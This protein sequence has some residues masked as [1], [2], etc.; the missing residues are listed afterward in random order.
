MRLKIVGEASADAPR[1][2]LSCRGFSLQ[3]LTVGL[4]AIMQSIVRSLDLLLQLMQQVQRLQRADAIEVGFFQP[5]NHL[6]R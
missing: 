1:L 6:L 2:L 3:H 4:I 5:V